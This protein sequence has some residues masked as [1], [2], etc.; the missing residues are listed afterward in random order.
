MT[1]SKNLDAFQQAV[2]KFH[3]VPIEIC[4]WNQ[5]WMTTVP[6]LGGLGLPSLPVEYRD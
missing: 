1:T 3:Q 2:S 5:L 6:L 4:E